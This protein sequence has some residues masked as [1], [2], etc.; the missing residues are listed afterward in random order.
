[1]KRIFL[2]L[3]SLSAF[4]L[5]SQNERDSTIHDIVYPSLYQDYKL[6]KSEI[7]KL[8]KTYGYETELKYYLINAS[9]A[10]GDLDFF[11]AELTTL[12]KEYGFNFAYEPEDKSY[13]EAISTGSL[14][15]WFKDMYLKNH[16][17]WLDNNFLKQADLQQLNGLHNKTLIY[18]KLRYTLDQKVTLDSIQK[19]EQ[20]KVF[21][22][23][24]FENLSELYALT[25]KLDKYP[26]GKNFALVQNSFASLEYQNFGI[27]RNFEK[28]WML[29]EPFYRKA[30]LEHAI[31]YII[32]RNYDNYSFI[33][34]K[35]QRYGLI[36]IFDIPEVYQEDMFSV[37]IR[38]LEFAN[39]TKTDFNWKNN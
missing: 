31:D 39:K 6:A 12:V 1:M 27:E 23:M 16:V 3:F 15:G 25:R 11:K 10:E 20:K 21:E 2:I 35:N 18:N 7:L 38:D 9:F 22:D 33:H 28:S 13:Y 26:T 36:S 4:A 5:H 30:Y 37:P 19:I 24:A 29:F 14:A 34:Y 32:Y 8:E 17:I